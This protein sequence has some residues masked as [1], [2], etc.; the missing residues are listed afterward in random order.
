LGAHGIIGV[1][2]PLAGRA[3]LVVEARFGF[4]RAPAEGIPDVSYSMG[5]VALMTGVRF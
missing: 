1:E 3:R 4:F 2:P 5:V